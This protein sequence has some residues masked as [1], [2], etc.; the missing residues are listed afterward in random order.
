MPGGWEDSFRDELHPKVEP[1]ASLPRWDR[2]P[3]W[4]GTRRAPGATHFRRRAI[5]SALAHCRL[6]P[7]APA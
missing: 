4:P 7:G 5:T 2:E 6:L 3:V 1:M